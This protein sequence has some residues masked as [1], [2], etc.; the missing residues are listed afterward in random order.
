MLVDLARNDVARIS[1]S[2]TRQVTRLLTIARYARV[3]HLVSRVEGLL[4]PGID[5]LIAYAACANM[6]TL[7]GA[8]KLRAAALLREY[9]YTRRGSYGGAVGYFACDGSLDSCI[10]IRSALVHDGVAWVRAGA[11]VVASS[12]PAAEV[13]E[14]RRKAEAVL[15]A[16]ASVEELQR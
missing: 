16:I 2:G 10:V 6:G 12:H 5:A 14:T 4:R 11:G 15:G 9:E 1:R 13:A 7:V 8:P 3:M